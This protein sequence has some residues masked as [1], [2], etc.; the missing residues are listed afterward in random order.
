MICIGYVTHLNYSFTYVNVITSL[1]KHIYI[2]CTISVCL[3]YP[4]MHGHAYRTEEQCVVVT[5]DRRSSQGPHLLPPPLPW[6]C[7]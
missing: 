4:S 5:K 2:L 3:T 7:G 1:N 6:L